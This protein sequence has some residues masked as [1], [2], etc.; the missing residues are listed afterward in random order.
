M[1][2]DI[3]FSLDMFTFHMYN[4]DNNGKDVPKTY[5]LRILEFGAPTRYRSLL[6]LRLCIDKTIG[7]ILYIESFK[8]SK[9]F[10]L[11]KGKPEPTLNEEEHVTKDD[12][13]SC[14]S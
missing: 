7:V 8:F 2:R 12:T 14:V 11:R 3:E 1:K 9:I 6:H 5:T 13:Y 4:R 10:I